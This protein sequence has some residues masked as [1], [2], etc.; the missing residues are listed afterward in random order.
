MVESL[1]NGCPV[2][3]AQTSFTKELKILSC[4][5]IIIFN[6]ER[7]NIVNGESIRNPS[8][9]NCLEDLT[10]PVS[11]SLDN[12]FEVSFRNL[13]SLVAT[14]NHSG[15]PTNGHY[16]AYIKDPSTHNWLHCNDKCI[17]HSDATS[18]IN[19]TSYLLFYLRK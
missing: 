19:T 2:C 1:I 9:V 3:D 11:Q 13:Y 12:S 18:V 7:F 8:A 4:G 17:S 5:S 16:T 10:I 14:V 15:T 6:L